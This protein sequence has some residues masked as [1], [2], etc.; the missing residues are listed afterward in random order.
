MKKIWLFSLLLI[1][2]ASY[3]QSF[4][5]TVT[6][7]MKYELTDPVKKAEMEKSQKTMNDPANQ[8]KMKKMQEQMNTPEMKAMMESNPQMKAR[9]ESAMK[10]MQG[11]DMGSMMP[12]G[13]VI[14]TKDNNSLTKMNGGMITMDMLYLRDKNQGYMLD[15]NAKTYRVLSSGGNPGPKH[16]SVK[17]TVTKTGETMKILNYNCT[18]YV[19]TLTSEKG[20]TTTQVFWTTTE[21]KGMDMKSL[22]R[23]R[24]GNS[25]QSMYLEG[26]DG[27]PLRIEMGNEQMNMIMEV[28]DIKK[29]T[30]PSSDFVIPTD[31]K[32]TKGYTG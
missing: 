17:H 8:E 26:I 32:E 30:L 19:A 10:M 29:E 15:R 18:K 13:F 20:T 31:F 22:S 4:E 5:G 16:D 3:A 25:G 14:E 1:S 24:M 21:I 7:S 28:T 12:K 27:V 23:Q 6:W 2:M 11:G 9:M